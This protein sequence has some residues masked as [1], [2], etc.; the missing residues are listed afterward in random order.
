MD[1]S[2][3]IDVPQLGGLLSKKK[4]WTLREL[5]E[6]FKNA[7]CGKVGIEYMHIPSRDQCNFIRNEFELAQ[8]N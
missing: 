8:F 6:Q 1:K 7:Y 5:D 3:R 4:T 2:F